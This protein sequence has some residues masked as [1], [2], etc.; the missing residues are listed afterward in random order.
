M[1][2]G[3]DL[4]GKHGFGAIDPEPEAQEPLFHAEWERRVFALTLAT[5][6][7][8]QWNIDESRH[9]RERQHPVD[10]LNHSYYENWLVGL[11]KLL[12]EKH[13]LERFQQHAEQF[14][15]PNAE[16][17]AKI[18]GSGGPTLMADAA[19]PGFTIGDR[20]VVKKRQTSGH[21]RVPAY[22]QGAAGCI[23]DHYGTHVYPD[24]NAAGRR[25]GEHLYSV[26]FEG[27][28]LWGSE[29][30]GQAVYIDLW[31]PYLEAAPA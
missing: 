2:G 9:A 5:G 22:V 16:G 6:M 7:L 21:T 27:K 11:E 29:S 8:G 12:E 19:P 10:Y 31:E 23:V 25:H 15:V 4:G 30:Q 24:A 14:R 3:H 20:V 18:L 26:R 17:A 1:I 13:L 28:D